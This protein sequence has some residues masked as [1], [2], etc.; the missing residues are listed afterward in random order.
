MNE[1]MRTYDPKNKLED[2]LDR[3]CIAE[4]EG[5]KREA[6]RLFRIALLCEGTLRADITEARKYADE[7]GLVY[8]DV[9]LVTHT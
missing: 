6:N 1:G 5:N 7:T 3:A 9:A 2:F 8:P 4:G